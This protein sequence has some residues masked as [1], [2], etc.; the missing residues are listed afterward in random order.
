MFNLANYLQG[1]LSHKLFDE[2]LFKDFKMM[3]TEEIM[4]WNQDFLSILTKTAPFSD[5]WNDLIDVQKGYFNSWLALN[6]SMLSNFDSDKSKK[7]IN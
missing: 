2:N 1:F 4:K 6:A 5:T 3:S 7:N